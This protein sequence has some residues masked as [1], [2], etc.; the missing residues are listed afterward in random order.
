MAGVTAWLSWRGW[1]ALEQFGPA[2]SISASRLQLAGPVV[3]GFVL[4]VFS[5]E[6]LWPA[7]R[8]PLLARGHLLDLGYLVFYALLVIPLV[9]LIG[10]G[11]ADVLA[12]AAPWLV[13]PRVPAVPGW[14]FVVL[15]VLGID[16]GFHL[17]FSSGLAYTVLV[18]E[19]VAVILLGITA[20]LMPG[21]ARSAD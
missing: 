19:A 21:P 13:L 18:V 14:C 5:I 2:R 4:V 7:E 6:Q 17:T 8:R 12:D 10:A 3:I 1:T 20:L 16:A 15:A 9:V 11:F